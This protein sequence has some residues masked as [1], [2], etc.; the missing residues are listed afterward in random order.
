MRERKQIKDGGQRYKDNVWEKKKKKKKQ[1]ANWRKKERVLENFFTEEGRSAGDLNEGE[2]G[3]E[4]GGD[5]DTTCV[6]E[7]VQEKIK[8]K[9][10]EKRMGEIKREKRE[11]I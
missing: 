10:K 2:K 8:E 6:E 11:I 1:R 5:R 9:E 4:G 7:I 3:K